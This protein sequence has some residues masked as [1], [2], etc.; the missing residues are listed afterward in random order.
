MTLKR[1]RPGTEKERRKKRDKEGDGGGKGRADD[2]FLMA[3]HYDKR[4]TNNKLSNTAAQNSS[5]KTTL[6]DKA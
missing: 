3:V 1:G 6:V 2:L 4:L 5:G